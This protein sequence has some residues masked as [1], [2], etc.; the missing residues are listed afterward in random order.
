M[1]QFWEHARTWKWSA[2]STIIL[3]RAGAGPACLPVGSLRPLFR[4]EPWAGDQGK[5][6]WSH[7]P[8][9]QWCPQRCAMRWAGWTGA[10]P[11][12]PGHAAPGVT[13]GRAGRTWHLCN[14]A[15]LSSRPCL[16]LPKWTFSRLHSASRPPL[17]WFCRATTDQTSGEDLVT[18]YWST[19]LRRTGKVRQRR[20]RR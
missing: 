18:S 20:P 5:T 6:D 8:L 14:T 10:W 17:L 11:L 9:S 3:G 2:A 7:A 1:L 12:R 16:W 13:E 4:P 19:L 15:S